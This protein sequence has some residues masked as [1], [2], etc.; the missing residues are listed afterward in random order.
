MKN[1]L[2]ARWENL[3]MANYEVNPELLLPYVPVGTELDFFEGKVYVSLVGFMFLKSKIFSFPI[4][5]FGTFEEVNL[6]FYVKRIVNGETRRGVVFIN[7]TVPNKIVAWLANALYKE[8]YTAIPTKHNWRINDTD[9][10]IA[11]YWKVANAW[12]HIKVNANVKK[13]KMIE[14]EFEAFIFEHYYGYTYVDAKKS[15][16]YK[17]DHP[18]WLTNEVINFDIQCDFANMYGKAFAYLK[19]AKPHSVLLAEGSAI[20][21]KWKRHTI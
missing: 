17:I 6:R 20:A 19:D 14:N 8:H 13:K 21:V 4:P 2:T 10:Q 12:N 3:I 5:F 1:F 18:S 7:E 15:L 11:Y 16:E 9:K